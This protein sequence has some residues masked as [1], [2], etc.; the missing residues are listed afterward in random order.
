MPNTKHNRL[1]ASTIAVV[2]GATSLVAC[3]SSDDDKSESQ[4]GPATLTFWTWAPGMDKVVD[5]WN[6]GPGR[7][8]R[9]PSR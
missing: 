3:G 1:V 9:S 6:K 7:S 2:L 4:S 8:S 5:L